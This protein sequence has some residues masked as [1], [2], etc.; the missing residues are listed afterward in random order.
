MLFTVEPK[1]S[2]RRS[3]QYDQRLPFPL[4]SSDAVGREPGSGMRARCSV[5]AS[6]GASARADWLNLCTCSCRD[7]EIGAVRRLR[8]TPSP[9]SCGLADVPRQ[10]ADEL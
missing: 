6:D 1:H 4:T 3:Y 10:R 5:H 9:S 8:A 2:L 7:R